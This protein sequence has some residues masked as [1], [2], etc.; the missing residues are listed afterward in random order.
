MSG[1]GG[2]GGRGE[3]STGG[4]GGRSGGRGPWRPEMKFHP[5]GVGRDR[6]TVTFNKVK[7]RIEMKIQKEYEFGQDMA[8]SL[9]KMK[10]VDLTVLAPELGESTELDPVKRAREEKSMYINVTVHD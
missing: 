8:E 3:R 7:E 10:L 5:H 1:R 2:R 9:R 4:R 6:Q